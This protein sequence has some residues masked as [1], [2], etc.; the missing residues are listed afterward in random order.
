MP[1][2][3]ISILHG[4]L[5]DIPED[6]HHFVTPQSI[7]QALASFPDHRKRRGIR[8]RLGWILAVALCAVLAGAKSFA[9]I[10]DW[11]TYAAS[12]S[13]RNTGFTAPH[14]TTFQRVLAHVDAEPFDQALGAW[15]QTQV[16]AQVIA[17]DG[18]EVRGA[19]NGGADRVHL[20]A[21]LDH[22]T[23][24][25][26][27]QVDVGVKT[28]E[29]TRLDSLLESLGDLQG[30]I[31]TIDALH[32][33]GRHAEFL[34]ARGAHFLLTVKGNQPKLLRQLQALPWKEVPQGNQQ[35]DTG[36]GRRSIR[37]IKVATLTGGI[38]FPHALQA[39]QL[40]RKTRPLKGTKWSVEV[41][42]LITSLPA[43]QASPK[44]LNTW[45]RGHWR[46][47]NSLHWCR[48]VTFQEDAS[49]AR[50]GVAPRVTASLRNLAISL[51]RLNHSS[52][53]AKSSRYLS[54]HPARP[55][56]RIGFIAPSATLH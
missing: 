47:E 45:I 14:V 38:T 33:L 39:A 54:K 26:I 11:S 42:Y 27:G 35:R 3:P 55:L 32:T 52:N 31:I 48:D 24:T 7:F 21:A 5:E 36:H 2:S 25:V 29:I 46:I 44:Q 19:K 28:N 15:M 51:H 10:A 1:S 8:H 37:R 53:I 20:M 18:K 23:G 43:H 13:L 40:T 17:V 4:Q 50:T 34:H 16:Q 12:T 56:E 30:R 41:V 6:L 22:E 49:H 9:A